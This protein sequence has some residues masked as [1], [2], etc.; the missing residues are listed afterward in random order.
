MATE[1]IATP[2]LEPAVDAAA[3]AV[4]DA[5]A[6]AVA[7][8]VAD[9]VTDAAPAVEAADVAAEA[10]T[11][12]PAEAS[13]EASA[14]VQ[15]ATGEAAS[16][17]VAPTNYADA[18]A[19]A[20][21]KVA[22]ARRGQRPPKAQDGRPPRPRPAVAP[23]PPKPP[24]EPSAADK[25][26]DP[27]VE[28][29]RVAM[30]AGVPVDG[31]V[32]GWNKGGFHVSLHGV[33]AF[34]PTSQME[35]GAAAEPATYVDKTFAFRVLREEKE[36]RRF[37][38]SRAQVLNVEREAHAAEAR[39][40]IA[41][42][43]VLTGRVT[44]VPAF[45]AFVDLGGVEGLVHVSEI[46]RKRIEKPSDALTVG[47]EV[48]VKVLKIDQGG[49]RV[50]LSIKEL[51]PDPWDALLGTLSAGGQFT[52][53]VARKSAFGLFVEVAP[54]LEGLLH[55]SQLQP[56]TGIDHPS[57]AIGQTINGWIREIDKDKRRLALAMREVAV[58]DPWKDFD[59]KY[60]EGLVVETSVEKTTPGGAI[61]QLE[62]GLTGMLPNSEMKLPPGMDPR[63]VYSPGK[64][65]KV[66][67]SSVDH[68]RRRISFAP[69][70]SKVEGS[71][72]DYQ[73]YAKKSSSEKSLGAMAAALAK[74]K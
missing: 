41:P 40:K 46:S 37:V 28:Q 62:P 42:G 24:G 66:V 56:G 2:V 35:L 29:L 5:G 51:E 12:A 68:K 7:D 21:A 17:A 54:G 49:K 47:Q 44:S 18:R 9:V 32:F 55:V 27:I 60:Q 69:E 23:R 73:A 43:A 22:A 16:P 3:E 63:R 59:T 67:I 6:D 58:G 36:G 10:P 31:S 50:S 61:L 70:G 52:G 25:A 34:C 33:P 57:L 48:T 72:S 8:A 38:V 45:G 39:A 65:V 71:R 15:A 4:A 19:A 53:T 13:A 20:A 26:L 30:A 1:D 74:L 64:K 14:E 11:E